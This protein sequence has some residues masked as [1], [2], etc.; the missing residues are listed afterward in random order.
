MVTEL[1]VD[2]S[3]ATQLASWDGNGGAF[4]VANADRFDEGVAAYRDRFLAAAAID[5]TAA[6]LDVGCGGGRTTLDA[7]RRAAAGSVLGVDLSSE[8]LELARR[9]AEREHVTNATFEQADAQIHPFPTGAFDVAVSRHGVMFFGDP[10][11]AFTNLARALRPG[12]RIVLLTWQPFE[13]NEWLKAFFTSLA[14]GRE[15]PVPPSDAPSPFALSDPNRIRS[16]LNAAGFSDVHLEG[17]VEPM[18][19]GTDPDDAFRFV[20]A[21]H[22]GLVR[23]LDASIKGRALDDLRANLAEH[24]TERGVLYDSAAW[25]IQARRG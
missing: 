12:G 21:Q 5:E 23:D 8:M 25:L 15:I 14:A 16:L 17:L 18:Y 7:A 11:A 2:A 19:F 24:H 10:V 22:A 20:S 1:A 6:V 3:N 13:R 4:W 9:R